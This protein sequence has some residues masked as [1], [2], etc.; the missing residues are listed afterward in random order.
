[1]PQTDWNNEPL[2]NAQWLKNKTAKQSPRMGRCLWCGRERCGCGAD[3]PF[4]P[5]RDRV[6]PKDDRQ[7]MLQLIPADDGGATA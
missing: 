6:K 4:G 1:M 5:Y 3:D 2:T 7:P